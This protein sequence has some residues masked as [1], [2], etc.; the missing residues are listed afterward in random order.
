M[1]FDKKGGCILSEITAAGAVGTT[2]TSVN[3]E[4]QR[5]NE[6]GKDAFLRLLVTQLQYQDPLS[7]IEDR[8][9]I[10]QLAQ[11]TTLEQV[12]TMVKLQEETIEMLKGIQ[13]TLNEIKAGLKT[14]SP[15]PAIAPDD[16]SIL[17]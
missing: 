17:V 1:E 14:N 16:D 11:F 6:L 4:N 13:D 5:K 8:E 3:Y 2:N 12:I 7:P 10:V 9:F 15:Q